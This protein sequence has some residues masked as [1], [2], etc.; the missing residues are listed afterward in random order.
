MHFKKISINQCSVSFSMSKYLR[1]VLLVVNIKY[2]RMK[3]LNEKLR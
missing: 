1:Y 2:I 3:K